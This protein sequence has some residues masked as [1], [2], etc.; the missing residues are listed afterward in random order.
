M[1]NNKSI[2]KGLFLL[3][4]V[5]TVFSCQKMVRPDLVLVSDDDPA[6]NGPLQRLW[7][8]EGTATDSIWGSRGTAK[9]ISYIDG[10]KGKA[11]KGSATGQIEYATLGK[12]ATMESFTIAFWM[13]AESKDGGAQ[14]VF[15]LPN[16]DDFWG[17]TFMLIDGPAK[18]DSMLVKFN[19]AGN[20]IEFTGNGSNANGLNRWPN[21]YNKW[22]HVAFTYDAATS[23]F[24][25]Y[26]DGNKLPLASSVTDRFKPKKNPNDPNEKPE[27]LGALKFNNPSK[28]VIGGF[29]QHIGII[30]PADSWMLLYTGGLDQFRIYTKALSDSEIKDLFTSKK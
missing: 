10:V 6:F 30:A 3:G 12:A 21:A 26:R 22:I 15:M 2:L 8:F 29:Q 19:F 23:K 9:G 25:A 28:F 17:N 14:A 4:I 16:P 1:K 7:A 13:K 27:P 20:W 24:A 5:V 18:N 11:Y